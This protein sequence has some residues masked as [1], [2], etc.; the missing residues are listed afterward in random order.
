MTIADRATC[1][2]ASSA[3]N[4][5]SSERPRSD[6]QGM[7]SLTPLVSRFQFLFDGHEEP[8]E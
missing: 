3:A 2:M 1:T 8:L 4:S 5:R 6:D 7:S